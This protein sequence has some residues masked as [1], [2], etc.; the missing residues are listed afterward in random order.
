MKP[1]LLLPEAMTSFTSGLPVKYLNCVD[2]SSQE[3]KTLAEQGIM[4]YLQEDQ[5]NIILA[6]GSVLW[7]R[8]LRVLF[9][10]VLLYPNLCQT[11]PPCFAQ[12]RVWSPAAVLFWTAELPNLQFSLAVLRITKHE[13][14]KTSSPIT[15]ETLPCPQ[16]IICK[17][18]EL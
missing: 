18:Q 5:E 12:E 14:K 3:S 6:A 15:S 16:G 10:D 9:S 7:I 13:A 4:L 17:R 11:K 8:D 1:A 2:Y